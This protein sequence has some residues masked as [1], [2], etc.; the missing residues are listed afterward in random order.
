MNRHPIIQRIAI[1]APLLGAACILLAILL[2]E[3]Y[4]AT[5]WAAGLVL[6]VVALV[7][8]IVSRRG[9]SAAAHAADSGG[10]SGS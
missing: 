5:G 4:A 9:Q 7:C 2:P 10:A 1:A 3:G 6:F 8:A